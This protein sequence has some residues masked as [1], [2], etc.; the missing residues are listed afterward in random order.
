MKK[1]GKFLFGSALLAVLLLGLSAA[2]PESAM[3]FEYFEECP[4]N[5]CS[6]SVSTAGICDGPSGEVC[7]V[8]RVQNTGPYCLGNCFP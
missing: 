8:R 5:V 6:Y 1:V 3:A 7:V 2:M 4:T